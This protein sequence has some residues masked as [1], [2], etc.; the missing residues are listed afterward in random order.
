M[1]FISG[2]GIPGLAS[3]HVLKVAKWIVPVLHN[4]ECFRKNPDTRQPLHAF[5]MG[6][7]FIT[8]MNK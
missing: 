6:T 1:R 5:S 3:P 7:K 8:D 2:W 4:Q